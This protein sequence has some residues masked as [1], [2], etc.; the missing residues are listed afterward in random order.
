LHERLHHSK[1][2]KVKAGHFAVADAA[3]AYATII[4]DWWEKGYE[5]A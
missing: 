2:D 1:S 5:K 3:D 4:L